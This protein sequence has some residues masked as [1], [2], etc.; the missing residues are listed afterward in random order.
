MPGDQLQWLTVHSED[1]L[2]FSKCLGVAVSQRDGLEKKRCG[3]LGV[4]YTFSK[5]IN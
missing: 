4:G 1:A 3:K 2:A 5:S